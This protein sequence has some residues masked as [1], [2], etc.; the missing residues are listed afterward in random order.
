MMRKIQQSHLI[1]CAFP[2]HL[3]PVA[4]AFAHNAFTC[5]IVDS[6]LFCVFLAVCVAM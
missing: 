2:F 5:C 4:V 6:V 3:W 1:V